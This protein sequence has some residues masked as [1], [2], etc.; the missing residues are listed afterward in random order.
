[1]GVGNVYIACGVYNT[2]TDTTTPQV[3]KE[4]PVGWDFGMVNLGNTST[5]NSLV[6][7]F[8]T[9]GT[10]GST[11]VLT[12]GAAGLDFADAGTGS[13]TTNGTSHTYDTGDTCTIDVTFTPKFVGSRYGAAVL[14]DSLGNVIA[15]VY[16]HGTDW[17]RR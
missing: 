10:L 1:M 9:A 14:K 16:I 11:A 4:T 7:T 13:C 8:D 17:G 15:T 3:L 5:T 2:I 12:Q 6:F